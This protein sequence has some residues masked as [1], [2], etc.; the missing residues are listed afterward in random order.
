MSFYA[1][2]KTTIT[3]TEEFRRICERNNINYVESETRH[4]FRNYEVQATLQENGKVFGYF[5]KDGGAFRV[6]LDKDASYRGVAKHLGDGG[7]LT[8]DYSCGML[9]KGIVDNNGMII[10]KQYNPD[11]SVTIRAAINQ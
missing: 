2:I 11:G 6:L 8:R 10:D 3:D 5:I 9:E 1:L 7:I 4:T